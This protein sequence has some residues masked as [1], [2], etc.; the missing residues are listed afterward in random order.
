[1]RFR[2]VCLLFTIVI[3]MWERITKVITTVFPP[4]RDDEAQGRVDYVM[5]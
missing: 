4:L 1:M 2:V 5:D 3:L